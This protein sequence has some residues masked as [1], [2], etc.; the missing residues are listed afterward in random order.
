MFEGD[1]ALEAIHVGA[2]D[3]AGRLIGCATLHPS[4]WESRPAWQLRGMAVAPGRRDAGVGRML[5]DWLEAEVNRRTPGHILWCNARVPA[6]GFYQK[7]GW[8][9]ISDIFEI[10]TAGPHVRMIKPLTR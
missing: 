6:A 2:F 3:A 9:I 4:Q 5:L 1:T 8:T 10:P 7:Q